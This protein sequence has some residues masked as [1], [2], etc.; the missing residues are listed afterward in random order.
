MNELTS[1]EWRDLY[2][3][4]RELYA[5]AMMIQ[6]VGQEVAQGSSPM[7]VMVRNMIPSLR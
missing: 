7:A 3:K 6:G 1:E 4:V 5:M 2:N